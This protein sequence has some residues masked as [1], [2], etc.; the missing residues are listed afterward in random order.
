MKPWD[1][2][3]GTG[4]RWVADSGSVKRSIEYRWRTS[5]VH[6]GDLGDHHKTSGFSNRADVHFNVSVSV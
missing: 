2:M 3:D 5:H 4:R 1:Q 6:S